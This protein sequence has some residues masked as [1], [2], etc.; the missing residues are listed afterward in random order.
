[1]SIVA[2]PVIEVELFAVVLCAQNILMDMRILNTM[3]L[4]FQLPM[5]FYVDDKGAE[6]FVNT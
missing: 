2:L 6:D 3:G 5:I 4:N 1:M